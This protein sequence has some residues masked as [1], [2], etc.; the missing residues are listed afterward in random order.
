MLVAERATVLL[1]EVPEMIGA[2]QVLARRAAVK[3]IEKQIYEITLAMK[4]I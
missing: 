3:K 2:E 1:S 4:I